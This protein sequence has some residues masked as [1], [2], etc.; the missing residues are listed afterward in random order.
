MR[1]WYWLTLKVYYDKLLTKGAASYLTII[2]V[3]VFMAAFAEGFAWGHLGST[4]THDNPWLG[5][6]GLGCFVGFALLFFDRQIIT[7]DFLE[8]K[9]KRQLLPHLHNIE[10]PQASSGFVGKV[11]GFWYHLR[12]LK[13][14]LFLVCRLAIILGS[15]YVTA[16]FLTQILF[17]TDIEQKQFEQYEQSIES[18]KNE[19]IGKIDDEIRAKKEKIN[20][21]RVKLDTEISGGRGTGRG[22][23][24]IAQNLENEILE[25]K[26][27]LETLIK[28]RNDKEKK[29]EDVIIGYND[30]TLDEGALTALGIKVAKDSPLFRERAIEQLEKDSAYQKVKQAVDF[31]LLGLGLILILGKFFQTKSVQLY[32]SEILQE[33]WLK[34]ER[35]VFDEYLNPTERSSSLLPTTTAFPAEFEAMMVRYNNNISEYESQEKQKRDQEKSDHIAQQAYFLGRAKEY[36]DSNTEF[37]NRAYNQEVT[38]LALVE[39]DAQEQAYLAKYGKNYY[40]WS[41][42]KQALSDELQA[43]DKEYKSKQNGRHEYEEERLAKLEQVQKDLDI[44]K[45]KV[46]G[47]ERDYTLEGTKTY[48][49]IQKSIAYHKQQIKALE[50]AHLEYDENLV[51]L[52]KQM[53]YLTQEIEELNLKL[54]PYYDK[55]AEFEEYREGIYQKRL[56]YMSDHIKHNPYDDYNT[57]EDLAYYAKHLQQEA[58]NSKSGLLGARTRWQRVPSDPQVK[59]PSHQAQTPSHESQDSDKIPTI[60]HSD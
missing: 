31:F 45:V 48:E 25:H 22:K 60:K 30:K 24:P 6:I 44:L 8:D 39:I 42:E 14:Y 52:A 13:I 43:I 10:K 46:A 4:F 49:H 57:E 26:A 38:E 55:L 23:G 2:S 28:D 5:R 17:K 54:E 3:L 32:F 53:T 47:S 27:E 19:I 33:K 56:D 9:H 34:Y 20:S 15:L 50:D 1:F 58:K 21:L 37:H 51:K 16:P 36:K 11:Q 12:S 18:T 7:A 29:I 40:K 35:G 41:H 59:T